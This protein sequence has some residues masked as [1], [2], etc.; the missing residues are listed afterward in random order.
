MVAARGSSVGPVPIKDVAGRLK[1]VPLGHQW[2]EA[3]RRVGTCLG[4]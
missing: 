2:V 4:D 3:A 1:T